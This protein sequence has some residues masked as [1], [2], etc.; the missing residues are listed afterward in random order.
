MRP[1][2][3]CS[4]VSPSPLVPPAEGG[5]GTRPAGWNGVRVI[6]A[7][8]VYFHSS[9]FVVGKPS[10]VKRAIACLRSGSSDD[11]P[12]PASSFSNLAKCERYVS[13]S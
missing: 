3:R 12:L 9:C 8:L 11:G 2:G 6:G 13:V 4:F 10:S 5:V 7:T 1:N